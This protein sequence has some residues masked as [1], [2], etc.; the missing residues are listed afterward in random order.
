MLLGEAKLNCIHQNLHQC[1]ITST[2]C[3]T[4]AVVCVSTPR[5]Y[6]RSGNFLVF[7]KSKKDFY[8]KFT[9]QD[10]DFWLFWIFGWATLRLG[11][12]FVHELEYF[13]FISIWP[14]CVCLFRTPFLCK[15]SSNHRTRTVE[16][17]FF[18]SLPFFLTFY[19]VF[20]M[21]I[22]CLFYVTLMNYIEIIWCHLD[23]Y[24]YLLPFM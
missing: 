7:T 17:P 19:S 20:L 10:F 21:Y 3:R 23:H 24:L 18:P 6:P 1:S 2:V 14:L 8:G 12:S 22:T 9:M 5:M 16:F 13:L 11:W 15:V 4:Q